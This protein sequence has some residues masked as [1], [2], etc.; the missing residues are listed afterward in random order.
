MLALA[1]MTTVYEVDVSSE[2]AF[3]AKN[4]PVDARD[5][6]ELQEITG[7]AAGSSS[8]RDLLRPNYF[9]IMGPDTSD[10]RSPGTLDIMIATI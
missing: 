5:F 9:V 8:L 6:I 1:K 10:M 4:E 7:E 2:E 3:T